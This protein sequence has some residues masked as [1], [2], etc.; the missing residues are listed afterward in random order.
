MPTKRLPLAAKESFITRLRRYLMFR[1][2]YISI[3]A[4]VGIT[5]EVIA[6]NPGTDVVKDL[7]T[8]LVGFA[9]NGLI[10]FLVIKRPR[11]DLNYYR[12]LGWL[13]LL[14]DIILAAS[15]IYNRGGVES[16]TII[17]YA[18]P[19]VIAAG[20]FGRAATYVTAA[21]CAL[22]YDLLVGLEWLGVSSTKNILFPSLHTNSG[23]VLTSII[24]YS[25]VMF[26]LA[27]VGDFVGRILLEEQQSLRRNQEYLE[28]QRMVAVSANE[29]GS[30]EEA[31][32]IA[33]DLF[34]IYA[35]APLGHAFLV[36]QPSKDRLLPSSVWY[37]GDWGR[38]HD[39]QAVSDKLEL[40]VDQG[41]PGHAWKQRKVFY[42][43]EIQS[44]RSYPR[45]AVFAKLG[46]TGGLAFPIVVQDEVV[47]VL[48][49]FNRR[50]FERSAD[51]EALVK[52]INA[53]M[54][55]V[56]I[57]RQNEEAIKAR[58][59]ELE[60]FNKI[61]LGREARMAELKKE[62]DALRK[63]NPA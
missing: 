15:L 22:S 54:G 4:G 44:D 13:L 45:Q 11:V 40:R 39:L 34:C 38:Y 53:Q 24:V 2:L 7:L 47:A 43:D 28:L 35:R 12:V 8:A 9:F 17:L 61:M 19:I 25:M 36:A 31:L 16:R 30:V 51:L 41:L 58:T 18:V 46:L 23:Y 60:K 29:A 32:K 26:I 20:L 5:T 49:F 33:V 1:W 59:E 48:E 27:S 3:L 57:R 21:I 62:L 56:F 50:P 37:V 6:H 52:Y 14:N 42:S 10:Q 55:Q 63:E